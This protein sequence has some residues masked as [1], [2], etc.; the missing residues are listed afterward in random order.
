[1]SIKKIKQHND[2]QFLKDIK[3]VR[4]V[5]ICPKSTESYFEVKKKDVLKEAETMKI[6]YFITDRV[7]KVRRDVMV[8]I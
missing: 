1:M 4:E 6:H 3:R 8:I 7:F 5:M 2:E